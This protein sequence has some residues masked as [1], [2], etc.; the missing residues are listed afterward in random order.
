MK[1]IRYIIIG[2]VLAVLSFFI[3]KLAT[4]KIFDNELIFIEK[5]PVKESNYSVVLYKYPSSATVQGAIQVQLMQNETGDRKLYQ[6]YD[7][8]NNLAF[9]NIIDG[10]I[11]EIGLQNSIRDSLQIDT[12]KIKLPKMY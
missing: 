1:K 9:A 2:A 12:I 7:T 11:L 6:N 8:Y 3:Y 5:V 10:K 4:F